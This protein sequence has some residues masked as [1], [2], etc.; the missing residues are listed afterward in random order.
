VRR[1][2]IPG[3][4]GRHGPDRAALGVAVCSLDARGD[5]VKDVPDVFAYLDYRRFLGDYYRRRKKTSRTFS[6]RSFAR[7]A[8]LASPNH[9]KRVIEGERNLGEETAR[10]YADVI[11][12]EKEESAYFCELVAFTQSKTTA[13]RSAS[14][15]RLT[16]FAGYRRAQRL[17][18]H[19]DRY[20]SEWYIPA[21][22]EMIG[23][24]DFRMD[25]KWIGAQLLPAVPQR[26][27]ERALQVLRELGM[28]AVHEDGSVARSDQVVSTGPETSSTHVVH[29]HRAM[30]DMA[31]KSIDAVPASE[32]D[33][34]GVTLCLPESA[35]GTLKERLREFRREIIALE[36]NV[37]GERVVH[38]G[39]QLFPLTRAAAAASDAREE[40]R[41]GGREEVEP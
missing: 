16:Q 1:A 7:R 2:V 33:I 36:S 6:F 22:R 10:K 15:R 17:D 31:M 34:S 28:I 4:D 40:R 38:V 3:P 14:Y 41:D 21:I 32:R 19:Q 27:V 24:S 13:E 25:A 5:L 12:L 20:H 37:G 9:L 23:R 30:M 39:I 26:Q 11:G 35:I 18:A 29:Y 8:G